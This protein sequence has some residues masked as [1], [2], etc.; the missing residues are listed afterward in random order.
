MARDSWLH[1][2][3]RALEA[4]HTAL[5]TPPLPPDPTGSP[6]TVTLALAPAPALALALAPLTL[7][8]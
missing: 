4:S 3:R 5:R 1:S 6:S 2:A 8:P 7:N